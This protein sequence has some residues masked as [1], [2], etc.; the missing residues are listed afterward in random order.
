MD[1]YKIIK[2]DNE[3]KLEEEVNR[4]LLN[5]YSLNGSFKA[6]YYPIKNKTIFYQ[7]L[8]RDK[9]VVYHWSDWE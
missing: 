7:S 1:N 9:K 3:T 8:K 4:Y 2:N 6:I 5:G